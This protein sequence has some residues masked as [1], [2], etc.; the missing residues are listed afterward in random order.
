MT[1][2]IDTLV[3]LDYKDEEQKIGCDEMEEFTRR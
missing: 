2:L 1:V 3:T